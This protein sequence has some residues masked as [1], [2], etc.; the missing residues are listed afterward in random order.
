MV[1]VWRV[2]LVTV[3]RVLLVRLWEVRDGGRRGTKI[4]TLL[5]VMRKRGEEG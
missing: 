4:G 3:W 1:M 5:V 2:L